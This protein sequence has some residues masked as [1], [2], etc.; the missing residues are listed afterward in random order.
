MP[1]GNTHSNIVVGLLGQVY[2]ASA[3]PAS[4]T[5]VSSVAVP[6]AYNGFPAEVF[7]DGRRI[8]VVTVAGG[9][10]T[11]PGGRTAQAITACLGYVAPFMSAKLAYA[12]EGGTAINQRKKVDHV[13]L[14]LLNTS[15]Q[16]IS[17]GQRMDLLDALPAIDQDTST[18]AGTI[19]DQYDQQMQEVPGQ[20]DTDARLCML[21]EAPYPVTVNGIVIAV[22]TNG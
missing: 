12:A 8:G 1:D 21:G 2:S 16:G 17:M 6:A 22:T 18:P 15:S 3:Q 19:W 9:A 14:L 7:A 20:W 5:P 11:L 10:V 4:Y 13:G